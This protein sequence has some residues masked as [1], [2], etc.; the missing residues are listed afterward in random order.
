MPADVL[1]LTAIHVVYVVDQQV[2][3][4]VTALRHEETL[5]ATAQIPLVRQKHVR[6]A[7]ITA[8]AEV[9]AMQA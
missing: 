8:I 5:S 9:H 4:T 3:I 1:L 2:D 7:A 6:E